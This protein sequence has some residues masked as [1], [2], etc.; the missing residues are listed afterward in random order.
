ML[1]ELLAPAVSKPRLSGYGSAVRNPNTGRFMSAKDAQAAGFRLNRQASPMRMATTASGIG[2]LTEAA[3]V[4]QEK[5]EQC[6]LKK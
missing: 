1:N 2:L 6:R 4:W 5:T 3:G